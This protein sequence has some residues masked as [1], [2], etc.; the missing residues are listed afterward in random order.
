MFAGMTGKE[1]QRE[2][3]QGLQAIYDA[4]E[5]AAITKLLFEWLG[6]PGEEEI[7][8]EKS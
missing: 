8:H 7:T 1:L 2:T 5:S 3:A 4:G 6:I